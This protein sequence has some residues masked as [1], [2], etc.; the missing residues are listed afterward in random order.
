MGPGFQEAA[1]SSEPSSV[2]FAASTG[3]GVV[4]AVAQAEKMAVRT[5]RVRRFA[6]NVIAPFVLVESSGSKPAL[7]SAPGARDLPG[8]PASLRLEIRRVLHY[9][10]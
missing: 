7:R 8:R 10:W 6:G 5:S 1:V 2:R 4:G 3:S 9:S